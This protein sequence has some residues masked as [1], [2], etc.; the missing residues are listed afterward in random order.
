VNIGLSNFRYTEVVSG[1]LKKG[2]KVITR[3]IGNDKEG[4]M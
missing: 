1:D 2:D 4:G 3:A